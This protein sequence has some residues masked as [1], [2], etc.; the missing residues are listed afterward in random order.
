MKRLTTIEKLPP[1]DAP[2]IENITISEC[3]KKSM[4][5]IAAIGQRWILVGMDCGE[6]M[7][8]YKTNST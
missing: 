5:F 2:I 3:L 4:N 8:D 1:V 7:M 6:A